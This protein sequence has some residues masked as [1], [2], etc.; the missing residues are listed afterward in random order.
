MQSFTVPN[1]VSQVTVDVRGA[2]GGGT[3][4]AKGGFGGRSQGIMAVTPGEV[5]EM[6]VGGAGIHTSATS[7]GGFNGGG[8]HSSQGDAGTGGGASDIRRGSGLSNRLIVAGGGGGGTDSEQEYRE[9]GSGGGTSGGT[10][11]DW[12]SWNGSGGGGGTQTAGGAAGV[13]C[14]YVATAGSF[15]IGGSGS[16][17]LATGGGGGGGWYGGGGGLF[18]AGGGGSGHFSS[19]GI[20]STISTSG[21]HAGNGKITVTYTV[22]AIPVSG[23][24]SICIGSGAVLVASGMSTYSWSTGAN[25][26]S[27]SVSPIASTSYTVLG[28]TS[29]G[30][31]GMSVVSLQVDHAAPVVSILPSTTEVCL[32]KTV[33]LTASGASSLVWN[34]GV[35][36]G[37]PFQ[38]A[39]SSHYIVSAQ[40]ACGTGTAGV[41]ITVTPFPVLASATPT[42]LCAGGYALLS[43][44]SQATSFTWSP[45]Q[46]NSSSVAVSPAATTIY[47]VKVSH[48]GCQ[49][50]AQVT[51]QVNPPPIVSIGSS[52]SNICQGS[53]AFLMASGATTYSWIPVNAPGSSVIVTP[54]VTTT[55]TV[56]GT[57]A[58]GCKATAVKTI[59]VMTYPLLNVT[60]NSTIICP[61]HQATLSASGANSYSWNTNATTQN[62]VVSPSASA[63]YTVAGTLNNNPC[64]ATKTIEVVVVKVPLTVISKT[65]VCEGAT[66]N[67]VANSGGTYSWSTGQTTQTINVKPL[68][69]SIYTVTATMFTSGISCSQSGTIEV[70]V[71]KK[72]T[73]TGSSSKTVMCVGETTTL[74]ASGAT[75]YTWNPGGVGQT[76][77][78]TPVQPSNSYFV[79][80]SIGPGCTDKYLVQ[81]K[82]DACTDIESGF[83]GSTLE[84]I[85]NPNNGSFVIRSASPVE[86]RMVNSSGQLIE[87][88]SISSESGN[89]FNMSELAT[90]IYYVYA[91][92]LPGFK[93]RKI[94]V[95]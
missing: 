44:N 82:V 73:V 22:Y 14:C 49:G 19:S 95:Q 18:G 23:P 38:P 88:I 54:S 30:C 1:C 16:G 89:M 20:S 6:W 53:G 46:A 45:S 10:G 21:F 52:Q 64:A 11:G 59:S 71:V 26:A 56:I 77:V 74:T 90:G 80:G 40:N 91:P 8:G 29:S 2:Q 86:L 7:G 84:V 61:G 66:V 9:G 58:S 25:S 3:S 78:F 36:N 62:I 47:T 79:T 70:I 50:T 41:F 13:A 51:V 57:N 28:T 12:S 85:P 31:P 67:L 68:G 34:N 76:I 83:A 42:S 5:L 48:H 32:G 92:S 43:A 35:V 87:N 63:V 69:N 33:T 72:P 65:T 4:S 81:I 55:Y 37:V 27:I 94:V 75:S 39:V 17:D 24:S 60:A 15:G 93:A